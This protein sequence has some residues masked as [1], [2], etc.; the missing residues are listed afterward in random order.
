MQC[1]CKKGE[2]VYLSNGLEIIET[3]S[4]DLQKYQMQYGELPKKWL[5]IPGEA[6]PAKIEG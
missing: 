2:I 4:F 5:P 3:C 6:Y 1:E